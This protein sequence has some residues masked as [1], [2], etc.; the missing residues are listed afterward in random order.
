[1][2]CLAP[3]VR[4]TMSFLAQPA[5]GSG[6]IIRVSV[7]ANGQQANGGSASPDISADG[8]YVAFD[9]S[10]SNLVRVTPTT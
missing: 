2:Q 6:T 7:A 5:S 8:R 3:A 4:W 1:M 10:A 9:S